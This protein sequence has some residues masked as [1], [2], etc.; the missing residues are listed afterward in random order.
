MAQCGFPAYSFREE[1]ARSAVSS[2][3]RCDCPRRRRGGV[4]CCAGQMPGSAALSRLCGC[5]GIINGLDRTA[6]EYLCVAPGRSGILIA[7]LL[8]VLAG[9]EAGAWVYAASANEARNKQAGEA[10]W[11]GSTPLTYLYHSY[12]LILPESPGDVGLA[13]DPSAVAHAAE[14]VLLKSSPAGPTGGDGISQQHSR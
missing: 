1:T 10:C 13:A 2:V 8:H 3:R 5:A 4:T 12:Q 9:L 11:H 14:S 6:N 7:C